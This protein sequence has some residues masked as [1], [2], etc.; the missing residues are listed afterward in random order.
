MRKKKILNQ[1]K[2]KKLFS[3]ITESD[4]SWRIE[5]HPCDGIRSFC[6]HLERTLANESDDLLTHLLAIR[7]EIKANQNIEDELVRKFELGAIEQ[8]RRRQ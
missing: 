5:L 4:V 3:E 7:N 1:T 6:P 2:I 8:E